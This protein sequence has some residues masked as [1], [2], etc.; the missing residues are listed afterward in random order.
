M[1]RKSKQR[2][3]INK[4]KSNY[5]PTKNMFLLCSYKNR[6]KTNV[7]KKYNGPKN[8]KFIGH[9]SKSIIDLSY[10]KGAHGVSGSHNQNVTFQNRTFKGQN[11]GHYI[12]IAGVKNVTI[13]DG[14]ANL[15]IG[16]KDNYNKA[17]KFVNYVGV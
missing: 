5:K 15:L 9:G 11:G 6:N 1:S 2:E 7:Y 4:G 8:I 12:E 13:K 16:L 14:I 3:R 10:I 17:L